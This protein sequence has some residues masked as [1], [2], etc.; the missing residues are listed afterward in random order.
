MWIGDG[1]GIYLS[2]T[3]LGVIWVLCGHGGLTGYG[4]MEVNGVVGG[5][6]ET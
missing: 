5:S 4:R 6:V 3:S 2:S 1:A